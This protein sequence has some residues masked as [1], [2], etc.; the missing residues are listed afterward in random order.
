MGCPWANLP[1]CAGNVT[2]G[3][4]GERVPPEGKRRPDKLF[5][6]LL[7]KRE[8]FLESWNITDRFLFLILK[9]S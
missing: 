7:K 2:G 4:C 5:S 6:P 8:L 1:G 3:V 9:D